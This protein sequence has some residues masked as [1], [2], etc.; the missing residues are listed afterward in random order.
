MTQTNLNELFNITEVEL[1]YRNK[2]S[3]INRPKITC[4]ED[5][6]ELFLSAWDE[7]KIELVEHIKIILL[8]RNMTCLGISHIA[9]GGIS[10]C[11]ADPK[12]IYATALKGKASS[13][14]MA[15]NHPSGNLNASQADRALTEKLI[16]AGKVL[17][18]VFEDH[19]ILTK[20]GFS[21]YANG[22]HP[23]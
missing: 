19:L 2:G 16:A 22:W 1:I 14:I 3:H 21:S 9:S 11:I 17:D 23:V 7:N 18:I 15:H 6:A 4:A 13:I 20:K 5:A 12:I 8:D 10:G